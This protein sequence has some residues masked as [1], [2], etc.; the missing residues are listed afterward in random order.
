MVARRDGANETAEMYS[1]LLV[2]QKMKPSVAVLDLHVSEGLSPL[3]M[4]RSQHLE[5]NRA[6]PGIGKV[7]KWCIRQVA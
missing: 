2:R 3:R 4:Q 7:A 1:Q 6:L 5:Q